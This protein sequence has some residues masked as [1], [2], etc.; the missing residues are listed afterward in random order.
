MKK[1]IDT[2]IEAILGPF[3]RP[4]APKPAVVPVRKPQKGKVPWKG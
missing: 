2:L 4:P 3:V 1:L